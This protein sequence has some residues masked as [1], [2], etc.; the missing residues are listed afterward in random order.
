[1]GCIGHSGDV[2]ASVSTSAGSQRAQ[3][4]QAL[5]R[6]E[7]P[8]AATSGLGRACPIWLVAVGSVL[9]SGT[10]HLWFVGWVGLS[11]M[12]SDCKPAGCPGFDAVLHCTLN[13][14]AGLLLSCQSH[15]A[16]GN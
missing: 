2:H 10:L 7:W 5:L 15:S 13:G 14:A 8:L 3:G 11:R 6:P 4:Q 9:V 12:S 16:A 1:M